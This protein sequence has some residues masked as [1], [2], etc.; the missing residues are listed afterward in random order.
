MP[1]LSPMLNCGC[2][3][4]G[5]A[6]A[7]CC[8]PSDI[9]GKTPRSGPSSG[10][11]KACKAWGRTA[12]FQKALCR[13]KRRFLNTVQDLRILPAEGRIQVQPLT[14]DFSMKPD[15]SPRDENRSSTFSQ[16][17]NPWEKPTV[18]SAYPASTRTKAVSVWPCRK[19][20]L[21]TTTS[22]STSFQART[23]TAPSTWPCSD[24]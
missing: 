15:S 7:F 14:S 10:A 24:A 22:S 1:Q 12:P 16:G 11:E 21:T 9:C 18:T 8:R 4:S 3:R 5:R 23:S 2:R 20:P 6:R 17:E 19:E 13:R